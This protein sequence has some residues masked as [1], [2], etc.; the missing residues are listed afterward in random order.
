MGER[1]VGSAVYLT[2]LAVAL[3]G[4]WTLARS[5]IYH[6]YELRGEATFYIVAAFIVGCY[7]PYIRDRRT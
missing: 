1:I 4:G 6:A 7:V 5:I 3:L 2:A